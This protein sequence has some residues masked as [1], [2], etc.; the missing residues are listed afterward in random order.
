MDLLFGTSTPRFY[1]CHRV[2]RHWKCRSPGRSTNFIAEEAGV[3]ARIARNS[4]KDH[5]SL[6][7]LEGFCSAQEPLRLSRGSGVWGNR[8]EQRCVAESFR[9]ATAFS[10]RR[11]CHRSV[12]EDL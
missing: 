4:A 11:H 7:R 2:S 6:M 5:A 10:L 12:P 1:G 9:A 8:I 3:G